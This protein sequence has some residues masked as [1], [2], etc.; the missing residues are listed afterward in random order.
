[1]A[2]KLELLSYKVDKLKKQLGYKQ[3]KYSDGPLTGPVTCCNI[4]GVDKTTGD[5]YYKD[6]D[7]NWAAVPGGGGSNLE[8][9]AI[10]TNVI[11]KS[12]PQVLEVNKLN[13]KSF[14]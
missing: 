2:N 4:L 5:L 14:H 1:M 3:V 8:N 11:Y 6:E 13:Y 12:S 9:G 10:P 7:G